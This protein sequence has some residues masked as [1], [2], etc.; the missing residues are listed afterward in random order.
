MLTLIGVW[1]HS[2]TFI[3]TRKDTIKHTDTR[4]DTHRKIQRTNN[5]WRIKGVLGP[6]L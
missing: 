3:D 6:G 5:Q 2:N 1:T 4:S